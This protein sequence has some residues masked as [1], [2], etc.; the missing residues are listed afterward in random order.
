MGDPFKMT[1]KTIFYLIKLGVPSTFRITSI[2]DS[3]LKKCFQHIMI[4]TLDPKMSPLICTPRLK[5]VRS[6]ND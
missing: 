2:L 1:Q 6:L 3:V 5:I 4:F